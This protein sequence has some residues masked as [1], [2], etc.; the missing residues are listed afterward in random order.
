L[1]VVLNQRKLA[2]LTKNGILSIIFNGVN[3]VRELRNGWL[4]R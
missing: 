1:P 2:E 3:L 4:A